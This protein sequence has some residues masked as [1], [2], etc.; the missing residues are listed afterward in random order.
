[1]LKCEGKT[2]H[3]PI[4]FE[5]EISNPV[6]TLFE[7]NTAKEGIDEMAHGENLSFGQRL[8]RERESRHWSQVQLSKEVVGDKSLMPSIYRWENDLA[9]P[10]LDN[11][12]KLCDAFG[13]PVELWGVK[14]QKSH[15][16]N[17]PYLRNPYFTGRDRLLQHLYKALAAENIAASSQLRAISGLGGI[18]KT[19]TAIE[20]AYRY[21]NEY[22][23]VLWVRADSHETLS[24]D[25]AKLAITINLPE[26]DEIDQ[27]RVI[28][29]VKQWLQK[30]GPWLL[31]FDNADDPMVLDFLPRQPSGAILLTTRSQD[32]GLHIKPI[33]MEKMSQAEGVTFLLRR[34]TSMGDEDGEEDLSKSASA[35]ELHAAKELWEAMDGLPLALDQAG[36]YIKAGQSSLSEYVDLYR[37]HREEFLQERGGAIPEHPD[38]VATTWS[39]SFQRV[40]QK[41]LASAE[42][43][44]FC[45]FLSP[46]AIPEELITGGAAHFTAPLQALT[47]STKLLNNTVSTL[48]AYSLIRRDSA[49]HM[50]SVHRLVQAVLID[51][52]P[53]T[54]RKQWKERIVRAV[55]E[56]FPEAPFK[57]WTRCG[58]L[59]PHVLVC[60]TWIE[61]EPIAIREA[62]SVF[63]KAGTYLRERGQYA[64][65]EPLLMQ[66]LAI[67][68]QHLG[69][70]NLDT[71]MSLSSL[72]GL[73]SY[74]GKYKLAEPLVMRALSIREQCLGTEHPDTA[75]NL[76]HLAVLYFQQEKYEQAEP[77]YQRALSLYERHPGDESPDMAKSLNNLA[78]LY[79]QQG[80][81]EQAEPLYQR[82]LAINKQCLDAEH[83]EIARNLGNIALLYV[84]QGNYEQAEPLYQQ[85]ISIHER[86]SGT[87]SPDTA[88]PLY[89]LAELYRLQGQYEPAEQLYQRT[90]AI[91][92]Q[93]LD[94][95]HLDTAESLQGLANLYREQG[96]N[97]DAG[98]FYMRT[99]AIYEKILGSEHPST[100][101]VQQNYAALLRTI[102][103]D[104]EARKLE[105]GIS[106][107]ET[108]SSKS[109]SEDLP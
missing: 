107:S 16:W 5:D 66:A 103:D 88:Y 58:R 23:A 42:L 83:P 21:A 86:H 11:Q 28:A 38:A 60:A 20:Y 69:T 43:L 91:R 17:V 51:A 97:E 56:V 34:I 8:R 104:T 96:R 53:A 15:I 6:K 25:F 12:A 78:V 44:R 18:G 71:A 4:I 90:L 30:H 48:R 35:K 75:K 62:A 74:Q 59:L 45:A 29:A 36:A 70:E 95:E 22:E 2:H 27:F 3:L 33:E 101:T 106:K 102:G 93:H 82:A 73:Y 80:K 94:A 1:V 84:Q 54:M 77:L 61:Q 19:Q 10:H 57:E 46:D 105:E 32:P 87:E 41:N 79:V 37:N 52:M 26:K 55:N 39:I 7:I 68:E 81:Y 76:N 109:S 64:E 98:P 13:K 31:I 67:R 9:I 47:A 100:Q 40:E 89:G 49:T 72:A 24:T 85:A 65:A 50:L 99:L 63:D 108:I 14:E 92:E